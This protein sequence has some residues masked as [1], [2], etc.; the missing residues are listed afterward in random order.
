MSRKSPAQLSMGLPG[1]RRRSL[2]GRTRQTDRVLSWT[3]LPSPVD[4]LLL[5]TSDGL[6]RTVWFSPHKAKPTATFVDEMTRAGGVRDDDDPVLVETSRQ[7]GEY[8]R[9]ERREFDL[10]LGPIGT[11]FQ[12]A[13]WAALRTI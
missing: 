1:R 2:V 13:V 3:V 6:L 4:D 12:L 10:P 9:G 5:A 7:L 8:F 11:D